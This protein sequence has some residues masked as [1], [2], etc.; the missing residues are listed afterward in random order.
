MADNEQYAADAFDQDRNDR[1]NERIAN[2]TLKRGLALVRANHVSRRRAASRTITKSAT[3]A[4][5][6]GSTGRKPGCWIQSG[7]GA[8]QNAPAALP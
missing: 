7:G 8:R 3:T 1:G 4:A 6:S 5:P 2:S